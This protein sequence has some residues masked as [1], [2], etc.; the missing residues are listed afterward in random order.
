MAPP[1][2]T[3][4]ASASKVNDLLDP[5]DN[6]AKSAP[7]QPTRKRAA[8][9]EAANNAASVDPEDDEDTPLKG[10]GRAKRAKKNVVAAAAGGGVG[11]ENVDKDPDEDEDADWTPDMQQKAVRDGD[12]VV[13]DPDWDEAEAEAE[14]GQEDIEEDVMD[15]VDGEDEEDEFKNISSDREYL[16]LLLLFMFQHIDANVS[17]RFYFG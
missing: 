17:V 11:D 12:A 4:K 8:T 14:D 2:R 5:E 7:R 6:G 15:A 1:K 3:A 16:C 13:D 10:N 9:I